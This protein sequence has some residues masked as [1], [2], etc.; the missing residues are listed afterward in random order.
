M[1]LPLLFALTILI[2]ACSEKLTVVY[3]VMPVPPGK[4]PF[5]LST[6][7]EERV[8]REI[9]IFENG[10]PY[11]QTKAVYLDMNGRFVFKDGSPIL[12]YKGEAIYWNTQGIIIADS[13]RIVDEDELFSI[14]GKPLVNGT[15]MLFTEMLNNGRADYRGQRNNYRG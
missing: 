11:S 5:Q 2:S 9:I 4:G 1:R 6:Y 14:A 7:N 10:K 8:E 13:Y 12:T 3:D 15:P